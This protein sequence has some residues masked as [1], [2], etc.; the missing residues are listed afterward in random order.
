MN[1]NDVFSLRSLLLLVPFLSFGLPQYGRLFGLPVEDASDSFAP[2]QE[3]SRTG[4][5]ENQQ[6]NGNTTRWIQ[7]I[8]A[9]TGAESQVSFR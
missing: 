8:Y 7:A 5:S 2:D 1:F 3:R 6:K 4:E 9:D